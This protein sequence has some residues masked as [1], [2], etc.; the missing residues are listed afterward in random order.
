MAAEE[1][2]RLQQ[3][4]S[5]PVAENQGRWSKLWDAGDFLPFDRGFANPALED[6]LTQRSTLLGTAAQYADGSKP[7][8]RKRALVPGCG[9]GY[10]VLLLA[11][12]GYD[13]YGLEI[14]ETAVQK[15]KEYYEKNGQKYPEK[16]EELGIGQVVFIHGDFF[17][18]TTWKGDVESL[19][20]P[21]EFD[22]IYDYTFLCALHPSMRPAWSKQMKS[23]LTAKGRLIC[24][25]FP[26]YKPLSAPG[27]PWALRPEIYLE[28]LGHPGK[29]IPYE[30]SG[31]IKVDALG[32]PEKDSLQRLARWQ[33]ER[34]HE[35][36]KG[37][38]WVSIW[39]SDE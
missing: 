19:G 29:D 8:T 3:F 15:C 37:T 6:T 13:A 35:V 18:S 28:H 20:S 24:L 38:D 7:A 34:T 9:R 4:F 27:P 22:L 16:D 17:D 21:K 33:P 39:C 2:G 32:P 14:S 12:F 11:S 1:V 36:G 26:T 31:Q 30:E 10:D 23:L 25:E 5:G